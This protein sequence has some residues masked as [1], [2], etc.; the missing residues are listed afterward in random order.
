MI[1]LLSLIPW[2]LTV[3]V[4]IFIMVHNRHNEYDYE[5]DDDF[6]YDDE[7]HEVVRVAVYDEKAYWVYE[8]VFYESDVTREP[9]FTTA[10]PIDTM[11]MSP[12]QLNKL[13]SILDELENKNERE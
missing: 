12:K 10:R 6:M 7:D 13:L 11:S 4:L 1:A 3:G 5:D 8:N 9:D 2:V